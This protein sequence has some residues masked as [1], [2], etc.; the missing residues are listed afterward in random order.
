MKALLLF[1]LSFSAVGQDYVLILPTPNPYQP[2]TTVTITPDGTYHTFQNRNSSTTIGPEGTYQTFQ[3]RGTTT[4]FTPG[5][6]V[7]TSFQ[8]PAIR[9]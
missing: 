6:K 8:T 2:R 1:F 5:G 9:R 7:I 3:S 4:T